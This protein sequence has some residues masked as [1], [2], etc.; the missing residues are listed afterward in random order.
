[1]VTLR[2]I[3]GRVGGDGNSAFKE[4]DGKQGDTMDMGFSFRDRKRLT[5]VDNGSAASESS[6]RTCP[7]IEIVILG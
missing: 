5:K 6:G 4:R 7:D 2:K 3:C 1:M